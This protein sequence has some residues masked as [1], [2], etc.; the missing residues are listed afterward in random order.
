MPSARTTAGRDCGAAWDMRR[1]V[2]RY[3]ALSSFLA[4][5]IL[6]SLRIVW[7]APPDYWPRSLVLLCLV[8]PLLL[9]LRGVIYGRPRAH[10]WA[11][12]LAMF[13]F[14]VGSYHGADALTHGHTDRLVLAILDILMSITLFISAN[15]YVRSY[16]RGSGSHRPDE[17]S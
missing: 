14:V 11:A 12:I 16:P 6:L 9:P 4:V 1:S 7:L 5:L 15:L 2:W 13:Y 8:G 10:L 17:S 3:M